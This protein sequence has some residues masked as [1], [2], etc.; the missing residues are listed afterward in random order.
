VFGGVVRPAPVG[1]ARR[2]ASG[3]DMGEGEEGGGVVEWDVRRVMSGGDEVDAW[4]VASLDKFRLALVDQ[5]REG[6][7]EVI[8]TQRYDLRPAGME[9]QGEEEIVV[10][11]LSSFF[12]YFSLVGGW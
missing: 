7:L 3:Q 11:Y 8:V 2:G 5:L 9:G 1:G 12:F 4:L 6:R 10:S